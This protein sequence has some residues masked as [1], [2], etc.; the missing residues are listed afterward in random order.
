M[1]SVPAWIS[2]LN[3]P[4]HI[5]HRGIGVVLAIAYGLVATTA[6]LLTSMIAP[7]RLRVA[8]VAVV[9]LLGLGLVALLGV[10]SAPLLAWAICLAIVLLPQAI[11]I[12]LVT[13]CILGVSLVALLQGGIVAAMPDLLTLTALAIATVLVRRLAALHES[14]AEAN[15]AIADLAVYRER[16]RM[17]RELHDVLAGTT[18]TIALKAR[19]GA[20]LIA[21]GDPDADQRD[22]IDIAELASQ[23][24]HDVIGAVRDLRQATLEEEL[25]AA[26]MRTRAAGI[27]TD[28]RRNG[29][30]DAEAEPLLAMILRESLTN[31]VRHAGASRVVVT[32]QSDGIAIA[33]DGPGAV[34]TEGTG[35]RGMRERLT[36]RGGLLTV[37]GTENGGTIVTARIP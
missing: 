25:S 3:A 6:E 5:N 2:L 36:H 4:E 30:P 28:V 16:A 22:F 13:A 15:H 8:A 19:L 33:D 34:L 37:T 10:G 32:V 29:E 14:L 24:S 27:R 18:T 21:R 20:E 31:A 35:I 11:G 9:T 1:I 12:A 23:I 26:T 7:W 17:S